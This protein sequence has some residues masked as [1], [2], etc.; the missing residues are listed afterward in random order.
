MNSAKE[1]STCVDGT[2]K[3]VVACLEDTFMAILQLYIAIP[4]I[5][6]YLEHTKEAECDVEGAE[7]Y[8]L[9]KLLL[10]TIQHFF[11]VY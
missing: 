10:K 3:V 2:T 5:M 9:E 1:E 6:T 8:L 7:I 4:L 11:I